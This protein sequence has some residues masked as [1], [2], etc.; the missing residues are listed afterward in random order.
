[1]LGKLPTEYHSA[2][3]LDVL[4]QSKL[5]NFTVLSRVF[6]NEKTLNT[7]RA[8]LTVDTSSLAMNSAY[9]ALIS[10]EVLLHTTFTDIARIKDLLTQQRIR[11]EQNM[12]GAGHSYAMSRAASYY[13][14]A[15][16]LNQYLSGVDYYRFLKDLL[17][18]FDERAHELSAKLE[19]ISRTLFMH[20]NELV[21]LAGSNESCSAF[22]QACSNTAALPCLGHTPD[23]LL[24]T[25]QPKNMREAF[26]TPSDVSFSAQAFN[27]ALLQ[28][29][30]ARAG[31]SFSGSSQVLANCASFDYLWNEVRVKGGA[32]GTGMRAHATGGYSFYSY[33][34]PHIDE[35]FERFRNTTHWLHSFA[36][37]KREL[38]GYIVNTVS[39]FDKPLKP[40]TLITEQ[41]AHFLSDREEGFRLRSRQEVIET[42][43]DALHAIEPA[44]E[45][46]F[47]Q[48][49]VCTF[50]SKALIENAQT[51]FNVI[52]LLSE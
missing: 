33:R 50:G 10:S 5:G 19:S 12:L 43:L 14:P 9:T 39:A 41:D 38:E 21:S 40:R 48:N 25:P 1:M 22:W 49:C 20:E 6:D 36:P 8:Y 28:N 11:I 13:S 15:A 2:A 46:V 16:R 32:Y 26:I 7:Y 30:T 4:I 52:D 3:E 17:A 18:H 27:T 31:F 47:E 34:D 35:T 45:A 24:R 29:Q 44:L 23:A 37:S 42:T 51:Q